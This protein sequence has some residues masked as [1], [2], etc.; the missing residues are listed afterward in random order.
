[1]PSAS[2]VGALGATASAGGD[3][4]GSFPNPTVA[5]I[6][7]AP[8][9]ATAA[10]NGQVLTWS[11]TANT[12]LPGSVPTGGSGGG[13]VTFFLNA[14]T[15]AQSPT[16]NLPGTP[17]ELGRVAEVAQTSITSATLSQSGYDLVFG[18][19]SDV[20][21]PDVTQWPAGLFD[22]NLWVSSN[23]NSA[24]QT[25]IQLK[26][27]KYDGAN[28]PTLLATSDDVSVY[29]PTV[30]AQYILSVVIPQTTV[31]ITDRI[32]IQILA[33]ATANNRTVTL[34]FGDSTPSHVHTTIPSVGGSGLVKVINGV[35]Q[36]P[37]SLLVNADVDAAAAIAQ[38]KISGLTAALASK[39]TTSDIQG[40]STTAA[41][42]LATVGIAGVSTYAARADHAHLLP[43]PAQIGALTTSS[44]ISISQG[45]TGAT[46][47]IAALASLGAL[48]SAAITTAQSNV[49]SS[50]QIPVLSID[51]NGR[52]TALSSVTASG[53]GGGTPADVQIFTSSGTWTKPSG[54]K[55]V[56]VQL[57]GGGGGG[58]GGRRDPSGSGSIAKVGGGGGG[59]GGFL[60]ITLPADALAST[61]SITI[62]SGGTGGTAVSGAT[63]N[64][65][66][67]GAGGNTTFNSLLCPGGTGGGSGTSVAASGGIGIL[68]A[69]TGGNSSPTVAGSF[70]SP[71]GSTSTFMFGGAG[72]GG[73]GGVT[74]A[75]AATQGG[76]GG[77][78]SVLNQSGGA[79]GTVGTAGSA[80]YTN[81]AAS[82]GLFAVGSGGGGGGGGLTVSG[83]NGGAGGFPAGGGGGG[84]GTE[85]GTTSGAGGVGG[86]GL[87]II[88][89]YF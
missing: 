74:A 61:E 24:N 10:T 39:L 43:T 73:G 56:H 30:T 42:N 48:S 26:I 29:D 82:T 60:N 86:A 72:G 66:I 9:A 89:T 50:T 35:M 7:G 36:S 21:D 34:K 3:L 87:A 40:L 28:A 51:A 70:G 11:S 22:F 23:A 84:G 15:A 54:A 5:K 12:W 67:G 63:G 47:Q 52:V 62:G 58:G 77:R 18:A 27:Y 49:G 6:N 46:T 2:D 65:G 83:G 57:L 85:T 45:G 80:G 44:L 37:A 31:T 78:S 4:S 53:G 38:A 20:L 14:G 32:Y 33:K 25:I 75:A 17:K 8:V 76:T 55:S 64:G 19:V 68:N 71:A 81:T 41:A 88:T 1:M 79:F 16:T 69:N 13:G 59:G